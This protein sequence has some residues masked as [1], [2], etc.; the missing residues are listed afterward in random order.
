MS[1]F[2]LLLCAGAALTFEG[3]QTVAGDVARKDT[4]LASYLQDRWVAFDAPAATETPPEL[5]CRNGE[6][7]A[8]GASQSAVGYYV[9]KGST[10]CVTSGQ[11]LSCRAFSRTPD[12]RYV[13]AAIAHPQ[14]VAN[15]QPLAEA[16]S[17]AISYACNS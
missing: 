10:V 13:A 4:E 8:R 16:S 5:F 9:L 2:L 11:G 12:G 17:F 15:V 14:A 1:R 7:R 6:W 3:C